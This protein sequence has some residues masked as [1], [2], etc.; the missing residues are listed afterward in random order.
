MTN[1]IYGKM[2]KYDVHLKSKHTVGLDLE[3]TYIMHGHF[4]E[5]QQNNYDK[6]TNAALC[7]LHTR[8]QSQSQSPLHTRTTSHC[9]DLHQNLFIVCIQEP[10]RTIPQQYAT[11]QS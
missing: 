2:H 3:F 6:D 7:P 11:L 5:I 4:H 1:A 9:L 8:S 10:V